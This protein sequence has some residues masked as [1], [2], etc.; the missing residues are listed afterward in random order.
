MK[1]NVEELK[2]NLKL[3]KDA[4]GKNDYENKFYFT[5]KAIYSISG[6]LFVKVAFE[7]DQ[8]FTVEGK[9]FTAFINKIRS[10][11]IELEVG[12]N[13]VLI[14]TSK[15]RSEFPLFKE[16]QAIPTEIFDT[17][18]ATAPVDLAE[19]IETVAY[20]TSK[21]K[22]RPHLTG[23]MLRGNFAEAT[24]CRQV[25]IST[26]DGDIEPIII[27]HTIVKYIKELGIAKYAI[28]GDWWVFE[29]TTGVSFACSRLEGEFPKR[30]QLDN[31]VD[32]E[33]EETIK[34]PIKDTIEALETC[35]VFLANVDDLNK[36][37]LVE[38][39]NGKA[40]ITAKSLNGQ[41]KEKVAVEFDGEMTFGINPD[42]FK[43][44]LNKTDA[45]G[46][47][48]GRMI[49]ESDDNKSVIALANID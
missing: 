17:P 22:A 34:F 46:V 18:L 27:P 8:Q 36:L 20:A 38:V 33:I 24:D 43:A 42:F 32:V 2:G 26:F 6:K 40:M 48:D 13:S 30:E 41:H 39:K 49:F 35:S 28:E 25:S 1:I 47:R 4:L 10:K 31:I 3:L 16:E 9:P 14:K 29:T 19:A 12:E 5:N 21:N 11:E 23:I 15:S 7:T 45:V 37:V 44:I